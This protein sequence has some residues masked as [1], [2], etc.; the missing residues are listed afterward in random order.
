[1]ELEARNHIEFLAVPTHT[2][3]NNVMEMIQIQ[4]QLGYVKSNLT[5]QQMFNSSFL[6]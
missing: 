5:I 2:F 3:E 6:P 4:K 1:M